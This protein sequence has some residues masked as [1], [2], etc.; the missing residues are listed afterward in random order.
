M[1]QITVAKPTF[2]GDIP[3]STLSNWIE[4]YQNNTSAVA[5]VWMKNSSM[6]GRSSILC[7]IIKTLNT[8]RNITGNQM[9][10][11]CPS[12]S[13]LAYIERFIG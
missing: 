11:Q 4:V 10:P 8:F 2:H 1:L 12:K 13:A 5:K 7:Q 3:L 6:L 9:A